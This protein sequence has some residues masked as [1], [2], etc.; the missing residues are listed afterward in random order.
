MESLTSH[1]LLIYHSDSKIYEGI[2]S[3]KLPGLKIQSATRPKE[4]LG[5]V[6]EADIILSWK[7]SDDLLRRAKHLKWFA[8]MAAGNERLVKNPYLPESVPLTKTTCYGEMMAEYVFTYLLYCN[9]NVAKHM[10]DQR[11]KV[12]DQVRPTRLR[13]KVLG[14]L[15]L[16]SVG[17]EIAKRGKQFGMRVLGLKRVP[18]PVKNVD[19]VFGSDDLEKMIPLVDYLI[20][21]LPLTPETYHILGERELSLMKEGSF[22]FSIGRGK[23]I[24]EKALKKILQTKEIQAVLDVF[25]KE[26]LPPKSKLW[27]LKNVIITPHVSGINLPE[28]ISEEFVRNYERWVKGEPLIALVDREKGY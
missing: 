10:K 26:P 9:R 18:E 11:K 22:L 28:E 20:N 27:G 2:L 13:G 5:F 12:W 23:T 24:D 15:G 3:K 6:K 16:G 8:S 17:K 21:I 19:R 25:E 4:A 7:I 1:K 14:I